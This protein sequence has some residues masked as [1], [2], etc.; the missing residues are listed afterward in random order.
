[1]CDFPQANIKANLELDLV[2]VDNDFLWRN[3]WTLLNLFQFRLV[4]GDLYVLALVNLKCYCMGKVLLSALG[5]DLAHILGEF[6][7]SMM[8][9]LLQE[10]NFVRELTSVALF[11]LAIFNLT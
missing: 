9:I 7:M 10:G 5:C 1:M 11:G 4:F 2:F 6:A 3:F 8:S